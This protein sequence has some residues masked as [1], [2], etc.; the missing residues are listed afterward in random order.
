[1]HKGRVCEYEMCV[2]LELLLFQ[3]YFTSACTRRNIP[4][5]FACMLSE[6]TPSSERYIAP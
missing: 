2:F 3:Q 6:L 1:M 4:P 5:T